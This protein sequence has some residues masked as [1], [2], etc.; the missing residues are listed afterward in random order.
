MLLFL[1]LL[2][3]V[4][5]LMKRNIFV[6]ML[7]VTVVDVTSQNNVSNFSEFFQ[8]EYLSSFLRF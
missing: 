4:K 7:V 8:L 2:K 6:M 5:P 1:L 3:G